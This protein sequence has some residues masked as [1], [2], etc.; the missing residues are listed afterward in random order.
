MFKNDFLRIHAEGVHR[1]GFRTKTAEHASQVVDVEA[2]HLLLD[3]RVIA[4]SSLDE[5]AV[6][7]AGSRTHAAGDT[8]RSAIGA[9]HQAVLGAVGIADFRL[10]F[11]VRNRREFL[12][13]EQAAGR[14]FERGEQTAQGFEYVKTFA[15]GHGFLSNNAH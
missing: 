13:T 5:D 12:V 14:M 7:G 3:T 10:T 4:G 11:R 9:Q 8:T 15:P 2:L 6:R 1:A